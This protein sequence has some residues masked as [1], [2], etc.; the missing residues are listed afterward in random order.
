M[1]IFS[2]SRNW[3]TYFLRAKNP[4]KSLNLNVQNNSPQR[5]P[6]NSTYSFV[7]LKGAFSKLTPPG[8]MPS[9]N[10]KSIWMQRPLLSIRILPL[11]LSFIYRIQHIRLAPARLS[12]NCFQ[13]SSKSLRHSYSYSY[14]NVLCLEYFFFRLSILIL[15]LTNSRNPE[16]APV[17]MIS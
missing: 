8:E 16:S 5:P 6:I 10:P 11:C 4:K 9:T 1:T 2:R 17:T 15:S 12:M 3:S 13:A 7:N 14:L